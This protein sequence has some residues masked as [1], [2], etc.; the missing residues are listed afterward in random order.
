M[1][2]EGRRAT[3][4]PPRLFGVD[5]ARGIALLGMFAAHTI[6]DSGEQLFDGRPAIL[7]A[8]VA[9]VSLGLITGGASPPPR[10][11]RG[12]A[13]LVVLIRGVVLVLLGLSLTTFL[14]PPIAVILDFY[15]FAFLLL[16]AVLFAARA[17]LG[18]LV[19]V[20]TI[21]APPI[22]DAVTEGTP[23]E[24]LAEPAQLFARWLFYG[25]YPMVIWLAF[26]LAGLLLA[27]TDLRDRF[28]AGIALVLGTLA[29]VLGYASTLVIPGITAEAHSGSTAEVVG[30]GGVAVAIIGGLS[31]LDSTVGDSMASRPGERIARVLRFVLAPVAA[32]G[33]MALTLYVAHA[34]ALTI[35]RAADAEPERWQ[36]PGPTFPA[37]VVGSLVFA[38]LWR[39]FVGVGP[40]EA[41]VRALTRFALR[42]PSPPTA[43]RP[44]V[45]P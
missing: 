39:R 31:L 33:A 20:I 5:A 45:A 29:A 30:S 4:V 8:T 19:A 22:V 42:T 34:I 24:T 37:L 38:T 35:I 3:V 10:G 11:E 2:G 41:G 44:R 36:V 27:R 32:A 16:I 6:F 18:L 15:G 14:H 7:F 43:G 21:A 26:L 40:L 25:E 23:F 9:G 17:V 12:T 28:T 1:T 13:R